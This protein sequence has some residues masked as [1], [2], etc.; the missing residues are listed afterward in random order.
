MARLITIISAL[1]GITAG[2]NDLGFLM[3]CHQGLIIRGA[4]VNSLNAL[5]SIVDQHIILV[6]SGRLVNVLDLRGLFYLALMSGLT[7]ER[8]VKVSVGVRVLCK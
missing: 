2:T 5:S 3:S 6:V 7:L 8:S 4:L 1:S